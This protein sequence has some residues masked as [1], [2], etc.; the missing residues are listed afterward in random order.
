M[1]YPVWQV[2]G[3][4]VNG[5]VFING[6]IQVS[7]QELV[8]D[9]PVPNSLGGI[10]DFPTRKTL[11]EFCDKIFEDTQKQVE[12]GITYLKKN[13]PQLFFQTLLTMDRIQHFLWRYCDEQDPT[14]PGETEYK[15]VI[16]RFY[17]YIDEVIGMFLD[18]IEPETLL[19]VV[20]D[21]GHG[22]RC[23]H[24]FNI[25][26]YFR[27]K[28]YLVSEA[29]GKIFSK[30]LIVEK[31]KNSV[32]QFLNKHDMEDYIQ[33]IAKFIPNAKSLKKGRHITNNSKNMIYASDFTGTNPFGGICLNK[34]LI[35]NYDEFMESL[36]RELKLIE[37]N[38]EPVFNWIKCREDMFNGKFVERFPE[39]LFG[40]NPKLGIN[41][42]LHTDLF[43]I[44]PTHKKISGGHREN[45][46]LFLSN[47]TKDRVDLSGLEMKNLFPTLLDFF[48]ITYSNKCNGKSF[49]K[50]D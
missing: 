50:L 4:M 1:A 33:V 25:N 12:F 43:T 39:I 28:G 18:S 48:G 45:G 16:E 22:M 17:I 8:K 10:T 42:A 44:N 27:K 47:L 38:G 35:D 31:L 19:V 7:K 46:V 26:E 34:D 41:W 3:L 9:I 23:T 13:R 37:Y 24:C 36:I 20:S 14:Y 40:M 32:L 6:E 49:L 5:P 2:N 11:S 29:E 15:G 30:Q 21:H